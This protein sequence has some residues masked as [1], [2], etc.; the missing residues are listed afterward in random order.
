MALV[1][2]AKDREFIFSFNV[3]SWHEVVQSAVKEWLWRYLSLSLLVLSVT[4]SNHE[5]IFIRQIIHQGVECPLHK[6]PNLFFS[7][8]LY[9][10]YLL[11]WTRIYFALDGSERKAGVANSQYNRDY[12][13]KGLNSGTEHIRSMHL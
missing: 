8:K 3:R 9:S 10:K 11:F 6:L 4:K 1:M 7:T 2:L 13:G 5:K 12:K